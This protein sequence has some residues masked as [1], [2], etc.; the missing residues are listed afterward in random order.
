MEI[1]KDNPYNLIR[2][3]S[4]TIA[5]TQLFYREAGD[6]GKPAILLLH[7]FPSSSHMFRDLM[8][9]LS[10]DFHLIAP[11]YPGFGYSGCP[12]ASTFEYTFDHLAEIVE[13]LID[14]LKL[15]D[16]SFYMQDYGGPIGFRIINKRPELVKSLIVQNAN[17][18]LEGLGPTVQ[19]VAALTAANDVSGLEATANFMMSAEGIKEQYISGSINQDFISPDSYTMDHYFMELPGR[20]AI[21]KIL[22]QNYNTN[23]PKYPEW[24]QYLRDHQ[25]R[26]LIV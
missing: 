5:G 22:F 13:E 4:I 20:K 2:Y 1:E 26:M 25:P 18:Y 12:D 7:G 16:I 14:Y 6:P 3:H 23:F 8:N 17:V 24:Q 11:D 21:Q 10:P 19:K 9:W 15:G